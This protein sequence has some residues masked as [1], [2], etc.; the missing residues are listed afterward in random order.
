LCPH[1]SLL[2]LEVFVFGLQRGLLGLES[3]LAF[4]Q[5]CQR[6]LNLAVVIVLGASHHC[7]LG[8]AGRVSTLCIPFN[9]RADLPG[10]EIWATEEAPLPPGQ[11]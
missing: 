1:L 10:M 5:R 6:F 11:K 8:A 3:R 2:G 4:S 7:T 9:R